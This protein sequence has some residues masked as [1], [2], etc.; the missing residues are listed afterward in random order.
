MMLAA[1]ADEKVRS[2][3][4]RPSVRDIGGWLDDGNSQQSQLL[5]SPRA[6]E[7]NNHFQKTLFPLNDPMIPVARCQLC[8]I[9]GLLSSAEI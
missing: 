3:T 6:S 8:K 9:E 5:T 4:A 1:A 2:T 7:D